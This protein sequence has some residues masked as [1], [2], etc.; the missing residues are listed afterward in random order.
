M[1][2]SASVLTGSFLRFFMIS[3]TQ[4]QLHVRVLALFFELDASHSVLNRP[5]IPIAMDVRIRTFF[6]MIDSF[7]II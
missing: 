5:A 6:N 3:S 2:N 4:T 7:L 1:G